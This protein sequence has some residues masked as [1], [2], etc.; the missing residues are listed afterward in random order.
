MCTGAGYGVVP[1]QFNVRRTAIGNL[2][3]SIG[4]DSRVQRSIRPSRQGARD[5]LYDLR[6]HFALDDCSL[7]TLSRDQL[8]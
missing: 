3:S 2:P 6:P 8:F 7:Q 1:E 5:T 4:R